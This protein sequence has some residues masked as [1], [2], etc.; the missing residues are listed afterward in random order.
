[1]VHS[2]TKY[3]GGHGD[4]LGGAV[5]GADAGD[6]QALGTEASVHFG[7]TIS[8]F[9]AWLISRG[10]A[11][12]PIRMRSHE[13]NATAVA[14]WLE[15]HPCV[16]KVLYPGLASHPQHELARRQM[17][18]YGGMMAFQIDAGET[19]KRGKGETIQDVATT[20]MASLQIVHY[21][22]SLGHHRSLIYLVICIS[23]TMATTS[24]THHTPHAGSHKA[25]IHH[26]HHTP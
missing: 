17:D 26:N 21:A 19:A 18:N 15:G 24:T 4:A 7:A 10:A 20:M 2:L 12:L 13:E 22:V 16:S 6:M 14:Q 9:N 25:N 1:V 5:I 8:P 3:I 11:T 23:I